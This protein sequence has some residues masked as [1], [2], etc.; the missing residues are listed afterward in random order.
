MKHPDLWSSF[1]ARHRSAKSPGSTSAAGPLHV[2]P[3][4]R[5]LTCVRFRGCSV[6][7]SAVSPF[8]AGT[9]SVAQCS[10]GSTQRLKVAK[11]HLRACVRC[12]RTGRSFAPYSPT[13]TWCSP[14]PISSLQ[15]ATSILCLIGNWLNGFFPSSK[16]NGTAQSTCCARSPA[17]RLSSKITRHWRAASAIAF[18]ISIR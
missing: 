10:S 5:S 4:N 8:R 14:R 11:P 16:R 18:R 13:W 7:V 15:P 1:A 9:D 6:G 17:P 12:T 3:R 2:S